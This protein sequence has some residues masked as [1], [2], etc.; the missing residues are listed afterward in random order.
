M[1]HFVSS[2]QKRNAVLSF[3][4]YEVSSCLKLKQF[5]FKT[6]KSLVKKLKIL[7]ISCWL[8]G[9]KPLLQFSPL[10]CLH[11]SISTTRVVIIILIVIIWCQI[12]IPDDDTMIRSSW[13]YGNQ[14]MIKTIAFT[15]I[16]LSPSWMLSLPCFWYQMMMKYIFIKDD[17]PIKY[18]YFCPPMLIMISTRTMM[19]MQMLFI[20]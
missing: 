4:Y 14:I 17:D 19:M 15:P 2:C 5:K 10:C 1:G 20:T 9:L 13:W 3:K 16:P 7:I 6:P 12:V 18:L 11:I 8:T